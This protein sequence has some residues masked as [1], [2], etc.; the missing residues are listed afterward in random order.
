MRRPPSRTG[1][2]AVYVTS[3][4]FGHLNR[5]AAVLNRGSRGRSDHDQVEPESVSRT[6]VSGCGGRPSSSRLS[7]TRARSIRRAIARP[8]TDRRR[9]RWRREFMPRRSCGSTTRSSAWCGKS[10]AAV[11][12]DAP[13]LPLLA[14]RRARIPGFLMSNF[15]WADIYAP[16]RPECR[17]RGA[18]I[19]P[20]AAGG[21]PE[22]ATATFRVEP[23]LRMS[24][25]PPVWNA[26]MVV[27]Q[28]KDR[29][30]E[31]TAIARPQE[32]GRSWFTCMSGDMARAI[33]TGRGWAVHG[34]RRRAF[35]DVSSPARRRP[36]N[37]HAVSSPDWPGG[38]LIASCDVVF[39]KAGYGTACE[40]M[41]SG[42]PLIYPPRHG[43]AEHRSLDR[44]LRDWGG[45]VP[46]S[47]REFR[48]LR[49]NRALERAL[50]D[51]GRLLRRFR[52]MA[53]CELRDT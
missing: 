22:C 30:V 31:L 46:I 21:L 15:T 38:D 45:G 8:P 18:R 23:A 25:L 36:S 13:A 43:F 16:V 34:G 7:R 11:L 4:G 19:R 33:S 28:V 24:W 1:G 35:R 17:R 48:S 6:G 44:C 9:L 26:G 10:N 3:H 39:A 53:R 49:L 40:A 41:A 51:R 20:P 42:T 37:L 50:A 29:G 5:T 2:L 52:L 47:S 27:N 32:V 14:A 12:C